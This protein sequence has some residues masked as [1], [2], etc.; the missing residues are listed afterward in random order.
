MNSKNYICFQINLQATVCPLGKKG[1]WQSCL[2]KP[3]YSWS[4]V[5]TP[6]RKITLRETVFLMKE[7][8]LY[9]QHRLILQVNVSLKR[10]WVSNLIYFLIGSPLTTSSNPHS[11]EHRDIEGIETYKVNFYRGNNPLS[12]F[13]GL[14]RDK[15]KRM[16]F[17]EGEWSPSTI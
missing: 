2:L 15:L 5:P 6:F 9:F 13:R 8:F 17:S 16:K 4:R 14:T 12:Y 7:P 1:R 10:I 11:Q 3:L